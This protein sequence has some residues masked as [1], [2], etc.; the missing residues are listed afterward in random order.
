V[1]TTPIGKGIAPD[2]DPPA[3]PFLGQTR[4]ERIVRA[5]MASPQWPKTALIFTYDESGGF[6]DH[7][8]P[9]PACVPDDIA[10]DL[11]GGQTG[12]YDRLGMRVPMIVVSPYARRGYVSHQVTDHTSIIRL[13]AA[14]YG[15]PALTHRD[16]NM[17]PPWD[18]FDFAHP[19]LSVP[20]LP[21][22]GLDQSQLD[23]CAVKYPPEQM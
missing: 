20:S 5:A 18:M 17:E 10:P 3:G 4:V 16:A 8:P 15:L 6:Y 19:D 13:I 23:A 7:V 12:A 2:E 11:P 21:D 1:E 22:A 14:R 9:P